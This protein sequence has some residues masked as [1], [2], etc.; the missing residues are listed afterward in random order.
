MASLF[1]IPDTYTSVLPPSLFLFFFP[2]LPLAVCFCVPS[3]HLF[4]LS[5]VFP[6]II[7]CSCMFTLELRYASV[8]TTF[9]LCSRLHS[10]IV[11]AR[12]CVRLCVYACVCFPQ[13]PEVRGRHYLCVDSV[14]SSQLLISFSALLFWGD[15]PGDS[16]NIKLYTA[17]HVYTCTYNKIFR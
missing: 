4:R 10:P 17:V 3:A 15:T 11:R 2:S 1:F 6:S 9:F 13:C 5:R 8:Y 14:E 12:A 7:S 16:K